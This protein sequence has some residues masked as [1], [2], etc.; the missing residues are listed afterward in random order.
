[1]KKSKRSK[2]IIITSLI[3]GA[4]AGILLLIGGHIAGWDIVGFFKS[5]MFLLIMFVIIWF[6]M[7]ITFLLF[8][9]KDGE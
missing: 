5:P 9:S 3:F 4:V 7:F 6:I 8:K 1:M 2:T